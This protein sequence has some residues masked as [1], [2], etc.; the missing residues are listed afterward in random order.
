MFKNECVGPKIKD[1]IMIFKKNGYLNFGFGFSIEK[2][3][4]LTFDFG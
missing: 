1:H 4:F 3:V 2:N